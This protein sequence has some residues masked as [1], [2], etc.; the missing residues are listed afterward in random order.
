[1]PRYIAFLRAINVGGHLVKMEALRAL[2]ESM[3]FTGVETFIASG[4]VIFESK[5]PP[6]RSQAK[7]EEVLSSSLG[8]GVST[9]VR[10]DAEVTAIACATPFPEAAVAAAPTF[11]VG[12]LA[13]PLPTEAAR[14]LRKLE[15]EDERLHLQ[16]S[17]IYWLSRNRQSDSVFSNAVFEKLT[18]ARATF[19][20]MNTIRKL[21]AKYPPTVSRRIPK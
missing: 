5:L 8:Y 3:Q 18:G 16:G 13:A 12:F 20:G 7:I 19:R 1:M 11:C 4:N 9:F 6:A 21:A 14:A 15:S 17:E 10:S 2:F